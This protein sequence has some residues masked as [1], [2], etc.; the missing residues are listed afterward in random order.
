[1]PFCRIILAND[2]DCISLSPPLQFFIED[3][4]YSSGLLHSK[5]ICRTLL[6]PLSVFSNPSVTMCHLPLYGFATPCKVTGVRQG[7]RILI[8]LRRG[9][10]VQSE[11]FNPL[12]LLIAD[13]IGGVPAGRG[14]WKNCIQYFVELTPLS[15]RASSPIFCLATKHRGGGL[16]PFCRI[17]L[18]NDM[19]CISL[20]PP[21]Q[22]FIEDRGYSYGLLYSKLIRRTLL[23]PLP[24]FS[25][26]SVTT[27]HLPYC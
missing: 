23:F 3:R 17:I 14:G 26:P 11:T 2:M 24:V 22:F 12:P 19:D 5:L 4:G 6:F 8:K 25:N 1:M 18:A 16:M 15:L 27:C 10:T 7:R 13:E 9:K 21:L 20:S